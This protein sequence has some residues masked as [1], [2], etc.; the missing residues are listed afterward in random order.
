[1]SKPR[2]PSCPRFR[3]ARDVTAAAVLRLDQ[4]RAGRRRRGALH[5][6]RLRRAPRSTPSWPGPR[7]PRVR[8]TTTSAAS[9]RCS[10][11]SSSGSRPRRA[12]DPRR[13]S[14]DT[15][16]PWEKALAGLRTFLEVVQQ[17]TYR[18]IV[19]QEGPAVLGYAALPRAGGAL[20]VRQRR[21]TSSR[22]VLGPATWELDDEMTETFA[23]IFFGAMSS[24]GE[25]VSTSE[26]PIAAAARVETAITLH[27]GRHPG[28][29]RAAA[30]SCPAPRPTDGTA[31]R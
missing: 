29:R 2:S 23:R 9:R 17:P 26:D 21:S 22:S 3:G 12:R 7:S 6:A 20:D 15:H 27:P 28:P 13:R 4:A 1:M 18:R 30:S 5:R 14:R 31:P 25:S 8:S 24:A 10:R 19:I 16:D 11:P